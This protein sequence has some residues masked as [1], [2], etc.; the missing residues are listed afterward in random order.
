MLIGSEDFTLRVIQRMVEAG[1]SVTRVAEILDISEEVVYYRG[2]PRRELKSGRIDFTLLEE[3]ERLIL[4][5]Y[6]ADV[7][8]F[9]AGI[10]LSQLMD[11]LD[12]TDDFPEEE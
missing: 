10:P 12:D 5:G 2:T 6:P 1:L 11:Y 8:A 9:A 3:A 4:A 7:V